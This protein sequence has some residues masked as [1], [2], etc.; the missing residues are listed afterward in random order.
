MTYYDR[1]CINLVIDEVCTI[2]L[3]A[4]P[5]DVRFGIEP[6]SDLGLVL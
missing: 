2:A 1:L 6:V 5:S 4:P 3:V